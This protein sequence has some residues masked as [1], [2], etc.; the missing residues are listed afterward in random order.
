MRAV[1]VGPIQQ[2]NLALQY[3]AAAIERAGHSAHLG[4]YSYRQD[5]DRAVDDVLSLE[6]DLVGLGMA[7][8]NN[9]ADYM[10]FM[11]GVRARGFRG[12]LTCGGH[13]PTFCYED[14]LRDE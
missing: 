4:G 7:F 1:L 9:I 11:S 3:L 2:E 13:V 5:L 14:L 8:Q 6:P 12:H 10:A